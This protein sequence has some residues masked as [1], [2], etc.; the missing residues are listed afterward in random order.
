MEGFVKQNVHSWVSNNLEVHVTEGAAYPG[1]SLVVQEFCPAHSKSL[2]LYGYFRDENG[3]QKYGLVHTLPVGIRDPNR[4]KL[5]DKCSEHIKQIVEVIGRDPQEAASGQMAGVSWRVLR[6]IERY[7]KG[8]SDCSHVRVCYLRYKLMDTLTRLQKKL[9]CNSLML[10]AMH[11]F[12]G[13]TL[14]FTEASIKGALN[15]IRSPAQFAYKTIQ[16]SRILGCQLKAAMQSLILETYRSVLTDLERVLRLKSHSAWTICFCVILMLCMTAESV[17]IAIDGFVIYTQRAQ[18][19]NTSQRRL[20]RDTS[21]SVC[22]ALDDRQ[23][24]HCMD[25]FHGVYRSA[26][27]KTGAKGEKGFNPLRDGLDVDTKEGFDEPMVAFVKEVQDIYR[28]CGKWY[29]GFPLLLFFSLSL[30]FP[31]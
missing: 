21:L 3:E 6:A 20:S 13:H 8:C 10:Y 12:N 2:E 30:C 29:S 11:Y 7:Y 14:T 18:A 17:Q 15:S 5:K 16:T 9:L 31:F 4:R 23:F 28:D 24:K 26:K 27:P 25:M 22:K 19:A 1:I